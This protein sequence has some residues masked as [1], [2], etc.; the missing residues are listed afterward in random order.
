MNDY[1]SMGDSQLIDMKNAIER[2]QKRREEGPKI[3]VYQLVCC[4]TEHMHFQNMKCALLALQDVVNLYTKESLEDDGEYINRCTGIVGVSFRVREYTQEDFNLRK[5]EN[6]FDDH[7]YES[8]LGEFD[9]PA[10]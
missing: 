3:L 9:D 8:R 6:Y 1:K 5:A 7:L 2:E 10:K 4:M